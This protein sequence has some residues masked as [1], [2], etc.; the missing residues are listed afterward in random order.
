MAFLLSAV[1]VWKPHSYMKAETPFLANAAVSL[2]RLT[3][4]NHN[5]G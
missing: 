1:E 2:D 4:E 5:S 3:A